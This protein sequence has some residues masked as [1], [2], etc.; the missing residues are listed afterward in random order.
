MFLIGSL[1]L[2]LFL[3]FFP[4]KHSAK[5]SVQEVPEEW[6]LLY[7]E[8]EQEQMPAL[9]LQKVSVCRNVKRWYVPIKR[10]LFLKPVGLG[11]IPQREPE[12]GVNCQSPP[13]AQGEMDFQKHILLSYRMPN[14]FKSNFSI[15]ISETA[16][17][18]LPLFVS[19]LWKDPLFLC[20]I[21]I[22]F[23]FQKIKVQFF[24]I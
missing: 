3:G 1:Q 11:V 14:W 21:W 6:K 10:V 7:N 19:C 23:L 22:L 9:S 16:F 4:E 17:D 24:L 15:I 2:P 8:N 20:V 12:P 5:H 13:C 18:S